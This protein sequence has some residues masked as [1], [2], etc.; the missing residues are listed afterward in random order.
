[1]K[2]WFED[3][4]K[5]R[6]HFLKLFF[7]KGKQLLKKLEG[8]VLS[9]SE[10]ERIWEKLKGFVQRLVLD[11]DFYWANILAVQTGIEFCKMSPLRTS[12]SKEML[13]ELGLCYSELDWGEE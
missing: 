10:E 8:T 3:P 12:P 4:E 13:R 1:M 11:S 9:T 2:I 7:T 5:L 6:S